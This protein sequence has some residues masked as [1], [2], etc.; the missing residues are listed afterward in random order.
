M[1][2]IVVLGLPIL[3]VLFSLKGLENQTIFGQ[4][5][6]SEQV[7]E[8]YWYTQRKEAIAMRS[9]CATSCW[10]PP[11]QQSVKPKEPSRSYT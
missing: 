2:C 5:K 11:Y 8:K 3:S 6:V 1:L 9:N 10:A 7:C 4:P